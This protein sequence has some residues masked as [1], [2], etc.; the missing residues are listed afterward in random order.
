[1]KKI[2][3]TRGKFALV[4]DCDYEYLMQWSWHTSNGNKTLYACRKEKI[5]GKWA[6][7]SMHRVIAKRM[8]LDLSEKIDHKSH[9]GL[10]NQRYNLREATQKQNGENAE[11]SK[12]NTS[13][14]KG[15]S[16]DKRRQKWRAYIK[17]NRNQ[18]FLGRFDNKQDAIKARLAG[19]RKYFTHGNQ[20]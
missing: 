19:E 1:M 2:P 15:V 9:K 14:V 6:T 16:W 20:A 12:A 3:L 13:G 5:D 4:D 17:H 11:L 18:I 10:N 7:T 8:G